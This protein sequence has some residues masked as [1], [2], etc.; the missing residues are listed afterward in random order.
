MHAA[1]HRAEGEVAP[2]LIVLLAVEDVGAERG[3]IEV[4]GDLGKSF[5]GNRQA[6]DGTFTTIEGLSQSEVIDV[7]KLDTCLDEHPDDLREGLFG[8]ERGM[9][10]GGDELGVHGGLSVGFHIPHLGERD[11]C[12]IRGICGRH[13]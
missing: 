8:M 5:D 13:S 4:G 2:S 1:I 3:G 10:G 12:F 7:I 6:H 9:G 11:K